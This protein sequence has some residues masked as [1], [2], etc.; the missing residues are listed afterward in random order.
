M[1]DLVGTQDGIANDSLTLY[2]DGQEVG[3]LADVLIDDWAGGNISGIGGPASG[4]AGVTSPTSYHD[5]IAAARFYDTALTPQDVMQ[6]YAALTTAGDPL[7]TTMQVAESLTLDADSL[8][9]MDVSDNGAADRIDVGQS[10]SVIGGTLVVDYIGTAGLAAGDAFDLFDAAAMS[11]EFASLSLPSLD[12]GLMWSIYALLVDGS[13]AVVL[14]GDYNSD[15]VVGLADYSVWRDALG[16]A[17]DAID[18]RRRQRQ[19]RGRR[20][21]LRDLAGEF[22]RLRNVLAPVGPFGRTR[23][24]VAL[25][26]RGPGGTDWIPVVTRLGQPIYVSKSI[27]EKKGVSVVPSTVTKGLYRYQR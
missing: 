13:L 23:A 11:G 18:W 27:V 24:P 19:R 7:P 3:T 2:V 21:G 20:C 16:S 17:D 26:G 6:N 1:I 14:A 25:P 4:V 10:L 15:G 22:R 5:R 8:V 9:K 12:A